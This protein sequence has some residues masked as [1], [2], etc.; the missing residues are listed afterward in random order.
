MNTHDFYTSNRIEVPTKDGMTDK[1]WEVNR[2]AIMAFREIGKGLAG[3]EQF[4]MVMNM[5]PPPSKPS[6]N[7]HIG[8]LSVFYKE[9]ASGS[10][11]RAADLVK[12]KTDAQGGLVD[13][14][15]S[16]DGTWQN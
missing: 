9:E 4:C 2:R 1:P 3:M 15:V 5:P 6:Y 11:D 10:L 14:A 8:R 13:C 7:S 16:V 12:S